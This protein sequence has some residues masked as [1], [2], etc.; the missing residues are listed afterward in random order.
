MLDSIDQPELVRSILEY[1]FGAPKQPTESK[2]S[3][4][5][6]TLARRRK[7]EILIQD[8]DH[9]AQI[10]SPQLF[11]LLDLVTI[12][13]RSNSQQTVGAILQ[14]C[15]SLLGKHHL[16][17]SGL[18][19]TTLV[20]IDNDI[21]THDEHNGK[22]DELLSMAEGILSSNSLEVSYES[23]LHDVRNL[24]ENHPCT[25]SIFAIP[26]F[27]GLEI[28]S[29]GTAVPIADSQP[30]RLR[31]I[32]NGDPFL[33]SLA[34]LMRSFFLNDIETNL[35]LTQVLVDLSSCRLV[36]LGGWLLT[37]LKKHESA[38]DNS[39]LAPE[40]KHVAALFEAG[41]SEQLADSTARDPLSARKTVKSTGDDVS[42]IF[43]ALHLLVDQVDWFR[44]HIQSFT[45][46]LQDRKNSLTMDAV[47][48][49]HADGDLAI[50]RS[51]DSKR[52]IPSGPHKS[53]DIGFVFSRFLPDK[54]VKSV[55]PPDS[56]R[57]RQQHTPT[58][59]TPTLVGHLSHLHIRP[60]RSPSQS[61]SRT[62]SPS[63]LRNFTKP[64]HVPR[65]S[66]SSEDYPPELRHKVK[67]FNDRMPLQNSLWEPP[68]SETSRVHSASINVEVGIEETVEVTLGH[69]LTNVIILQEF[70]LELT[71]VI[72]VRA[73]LFHE[74]R[75]T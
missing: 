59:S 27:V 26:E 1:L 16:Y 38:G 21:P 13:L 31:S 47:A 24:L 48:H 5:P 62:Y 72:Q 58:S 73:T 40:K 42:P 51:K 12:G 57:G 60:S 66:D 68:G 19:R 10:N 49:T 46:Y 35:A 22:I 17:A 25:A 3:M 53:E 44:K 36:G 32:V 65:R 61:T 55:S 33:E 18:V 45:E 74:V 75:P 30:I 69:L 23:H 67:I 39:L 11:T 28:D 63:P 41:K 7:S 50:Q 54:M 52:S 9:Q 64:S 56:V 2:S 70:I 43:A 71:A 8:H 20:S 29:V 34:A 14:L 4:R 37:E 15:S 6:V